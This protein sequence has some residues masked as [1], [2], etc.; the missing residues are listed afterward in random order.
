MLFYELSKS[1]LYLI[2]DP[3]CATQSDLFQNRSQKLL[4]QKKYNNKFC[5][6]FNLVLP[7]PFLKWTILPSFSFFD[8][9]I[10]MTVNKNCLS[11]DSTMNLCCKKLQLYQLG[12][13]HSPIE[14]ALKAFKIVN[15]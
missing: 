6:I 7:Y 13:N 9:S 10:Q 4:N 3:I 2:V 5:N 14:Y 1:Y 15:F 11:L 8:F 12:Q